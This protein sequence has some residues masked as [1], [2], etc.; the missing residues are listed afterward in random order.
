[1]SINKLFVNNLRL[2]FVYFTCKI[3]LT[4]KVL[5]KTYLMNNIIC[6]HLASYNIILT[7]IT[8]NKSVLFSTSG[9]RSDLYILSRHFKQIHTYSDARVKNDLSQS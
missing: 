7:I 2:Y 6:N 3:R 1:M 4:E 8:V 5:L 9:K